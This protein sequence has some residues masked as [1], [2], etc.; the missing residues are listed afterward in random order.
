M[1]PCRLSP[2]SDTP[3]ARVVLFI[4]S[5][6][7]NPQGT[8]APRHSIHTAKYP[9]NIEAMGASHSS[10]KS[11]LLS[12]MT[13]CCRLCITAPTAQLQHTLLKSPPLGQTTALNPSPS[14]S[15][16]SILL[17]GRT[18]V[19]LGTVLGKEKQRG[20]FFVRFLTC[21]DAFVLS[22]K[23]PMLMWFLLEDLYLMSGNTE[24]AVAPVTEHK[25]QSTLSS[26]TSSSYF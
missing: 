22:F 15:M 17:L 19:P 7:F 3:T 2:P 10:N 4:S 8:R 6:I 20:A 18:R 26:S 1:R 9:L 24:S 23:F 21:V 16:L 5:N 11:A 13:G 12:R 25:D 14:K